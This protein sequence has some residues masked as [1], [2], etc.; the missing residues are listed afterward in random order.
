M[1]L[2]VQLLLLIVLLTVLLLLTILLTVLLIVLLL[3][4][5]VSADC[6]AIVADC[7]P[8]YAADCCVVHCI[9]FVAIPILLLLLLSFGHSRRC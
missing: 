6:I 1:L 3:Q 9:D 7:T 5:T 2:T 8:D 4:L